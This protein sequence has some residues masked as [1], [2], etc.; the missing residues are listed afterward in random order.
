MSSEY[1]MICTTTRHPR[2]MWPMKPSCSDIF[3][4]K[5]NDQLL[6]SSVLFS[7]KNIMIDVYI[8]AH[9][10]IHIIPQRSR[11]LPP[12]NPM[13]RNPTLG[14]RGQEVNWMKFPVRSNFGP[15]TILG[16]QCGGKCIFC[17]IFRT[18]LEKKSPPCTQS[19]KEKYLS[20]IV[21]RIV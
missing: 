8:S 1:C 3:S 5:P 7:R 20:L 10:G 18:C 17:T 16:I 15:T 19:V 6:F 2:N 12:T 14:F 9:R 11:Q 21:D 13:T 4:L